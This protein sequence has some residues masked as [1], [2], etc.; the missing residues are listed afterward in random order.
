MQTDK[1]TIEL[2]FSRRQRIHSI[3]R[4]I[5][6]FANSVDLSTS[7]EEMSVRIETLNEIWQEYRSLHDLFT[8]Y[9]NNESFAIKEE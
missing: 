3:L 8:F 1:E 5:S 4:K 9:W 2:L 7:I 6:D